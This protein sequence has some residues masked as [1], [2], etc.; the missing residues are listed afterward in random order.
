MNTRHMEVMVG[1]I[2]IG[3]DPKDLTGATCDDV[4]EACKARNIP[5]ECFTKAL[6]VAHTIRSCGTEA[7]IEFAASM[8]P[9]LIGNERLLMSFSR[10][11]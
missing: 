1:K 9:G 4:C 3:A 6:A 10:L 11:P 5:I 2:V 7:Q 8:I